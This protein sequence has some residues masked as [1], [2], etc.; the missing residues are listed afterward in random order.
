MVDSSDDQ[1]ESRE[2]QGNLWA[3]L[4]KFDFLL[5]KSV[6]WHFEPFEARIEPEWLSYRRSGLSWVNS[7]RLGRFGIISIKVPE[8]LTD[9]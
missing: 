8:R 3:S 2:T 4:G 5:K 9:S 1:F 6:G 7:C